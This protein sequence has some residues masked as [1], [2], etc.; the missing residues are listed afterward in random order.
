MNLLCSDFKRASDNRDMVRLKQN[1]EGYLYIENMVRNWPR[2]KPLPEQLIGCVPTLGKHE[3]ML[4]M[5][6]V[7]E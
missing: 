2:G 1:I 3:S 6:E 7:N 5:H 4:G